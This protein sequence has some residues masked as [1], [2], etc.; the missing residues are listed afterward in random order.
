VCF[1]R[2]SAPDYASQKLL[3]GAKLQA[4]TVIICAGDTPAIEAPIIADFLNKCRD[5]N[6][7][8]GVL[9][10]EL[11]NPAG[12]GRL[13]TD[14]KAQ[15]L[16]I[17]E[18]RDATPEQKEIHT[19]NSGIIF[20]KIPELFQ[21]LGELTPNNNQGEYYLTDIFSIARKRNY[22]TFVYTTN[23]WQA[24][25]GINT[26]EQKAEVEAFMTGALK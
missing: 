12:Y 10:M 23:R 6:C 17:V 2:T 26:P 13:V 14:E 7:T 11:P 24:F 15:L 19:C 25:A 4:E 8:F 21:S 16:A 1:D 20:A 3:A 18:D 5:S 9:G 22:P